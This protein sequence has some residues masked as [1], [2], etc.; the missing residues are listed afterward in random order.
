MYVPNIYRYHLC[1]FKLMFF[2]DSDCQLVLLL[3]Y[4]LTVPVI[5]SSGIKSNSNLIRKAVTAPMDAVRIWNQQQHEYYRLSKPL[6][7]CV[8]ACVKMYFHI[9]I[10]IYYIFLMYTVH[11]ECSVFMLFI[12]SVPNLEIGG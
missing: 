2:L 8:Y 11:S 4:V 3:F 9:N 1:I 12:S 5:S 10:C 6:R 7:T